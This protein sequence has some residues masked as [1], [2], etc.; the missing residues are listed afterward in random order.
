MLGEIATG[1]GMEGLELRVVSV[2]VESSGKA[3][4]DRSWK[5]GLVFDELGQVLVM[6]RRRRL[7]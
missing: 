2:N 1:L 5:V 3:K 4:G 7:D 6:R